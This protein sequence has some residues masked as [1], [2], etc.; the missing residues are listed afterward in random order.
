MTRTPKLGF[1]TAPILGRIGR[2]DSVAALEQAYALGVRHFD[3]ARSYGW[4]EAEGV[5]GSFLQGKSRPECT[6]VSKCGIVPVKRSRVLS[7][8]KALARQVRDRAPG[9]GSMVQRAASSS[10]YQPTRTYDVRTL[11][12]S[13]E[14]SLREL[15]T[16]YLDV[17]LLHNFDPTMP[18]LDD[19]VTW[20]QRLRQ[21]GSIARYG[22]AVGCDLV[23]GL[24]CLRGS[25]VLDG[26]VV[27][28][29]VSDALL[30]LS[31]EWRDVPVLAH[32]AFRFSAQSGMSFTE[33]LA[34]LAAAC[35]CEAA[36]CSMFSKSHIESNVAT[37]ARVA[38]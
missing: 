29:P 30:S 20:F 16:D 35:R 19:V 27:Q 2:R 14:T 15:R 18:G 10:R 21:R 9:A 36:V 24:T 26:A 11:N 22:F 1:G 37:A 5:L 33:I 28:V 17:L 8:A 23:Q 34:R 32:S 3:T 38:A 6:I 25:G 12:E 4:G 13:F 7:V 31:S